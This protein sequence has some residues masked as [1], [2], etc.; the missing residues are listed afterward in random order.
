[1]DEDTVRKRSRLLLASGM[2][3]FW[4]VDLVHAEIL[5]SIGC[6]AVCIFMVSTG[7]FFFVVVLSISLLAF[8]HFS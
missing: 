8:E 5:R 1:M 7:I 3:P 2:K 4:Y 6:T